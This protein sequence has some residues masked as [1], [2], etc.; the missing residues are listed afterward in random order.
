MKYLYENVIV[1]DIDGVLLDVSK[2][3]KILEDLPED[4]RIEYFNNFSTDNKYVTKNKTMFDLVNALSSKGYNIILL[5]AR[6][7]VIGPKTFAYLMLGTPCLDRVASLAT[8]PLNAEGM[9]SQEFKRIA[10]QEI[11]KTANI[12]LIIDDDLDNCNMFES[13]GYT[14]MHVR[15]KNN[16]NKLI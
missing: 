1:C 8:R 14:V 15:D 16:P 6:S 13:L 11:S 3:Y 12:K 9:P 10:I 4:E 7:Q 2:L 5:T